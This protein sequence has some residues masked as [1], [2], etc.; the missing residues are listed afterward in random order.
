MPER[1]LIVDDKPEIREFTALFLRHSGYEVQVAGD[2]ETALE[3]MQRTPFDVVI[4]DFRLRGR[5]DGFQ[6]LEQHY[7]GCPGKVRILTTAIS[8]WIDGQLV[9]FCEKVKAAYI[10]K[11]FHLSEL[12]ATIRASAAR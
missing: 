9:A 10:A 6:V 5:V 11:P 12:V 7:L 2:G 1:V 4:A 3:L 8:P